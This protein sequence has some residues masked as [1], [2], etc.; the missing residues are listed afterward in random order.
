VTI[1]RDLGRDIELASGIT[2][3]DR[4][5]NAP[6]DGIVDGDQVRIVSTKRRPATVSAKQGDKG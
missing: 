3:D 5:I 4:I 1:A 2:L 6:P